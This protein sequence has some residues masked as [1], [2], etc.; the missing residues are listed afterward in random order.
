M[1]LHAWIISSSYFKQTK[2]KFLKCFK[3]VHAEEKKL[4]HQSSLIYAEKH[5]GHRIK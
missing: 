1:V 2:N 4:E 3:S 5:E